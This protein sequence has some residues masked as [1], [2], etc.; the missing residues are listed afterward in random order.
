MLTNTQ[1][2]RPIGWY[3]KMRLDYLEE[4]RPVLYNNLICTGKLHDHLAEVD[5]CCTCQR[6]LIVKPIAQKE[7]TDENLKAKD[8]I[9][10]VGLMNNYRSAAEEFVLSEYFHR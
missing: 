5:E 4:H 8:Q 9:C 1:E 3:S 6:D 10:R 2:D 7:E